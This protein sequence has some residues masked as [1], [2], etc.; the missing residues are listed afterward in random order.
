M[1]LNSFQVAV[2]DACRLAA[3]METGLFMGGDDRINLR[4]GHDTPE[5]IRGFAINQ[6]HIAS[7]EHAGLE[8]GGG[9]VFIHITKDKEA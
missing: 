9:R 3:S 1:G 6:S 2:R 4:A 5:L 8:R 7:R